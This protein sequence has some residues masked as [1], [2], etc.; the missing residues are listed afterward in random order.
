M[1]IVP[2][3]YDLGVIWEKRIVIGGLVGMW[4]TLRDGVEVWS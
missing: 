3:L 4:K 2:S 1:G